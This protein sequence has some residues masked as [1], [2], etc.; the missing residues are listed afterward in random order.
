MLAKKKLLCYTIGV[1]RKREKNM[2]KTNQKTEQVS[3]PE[4]VSKLQPFPLVENEDYLLKL[5]SGDYAVAYWSQGQFY[6][7]FGDLY[8]E[9][10]IVGIVALKDL[11]L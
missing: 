6:S 8:I 1:Q 3:A 2:R 11:G 4:Q 9:E 7:G 5:K 10:E